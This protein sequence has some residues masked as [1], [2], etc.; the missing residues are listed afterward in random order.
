MSYP[1][2][3]EAVAVRLYRVVGEQL[4]ACE[5]VQFRDGAAAVDT[6]LRRARD[7]GRVDFEGEVQNHFADLLDADGDILATV[8]LDAGSYGALKN[9]WMRTR[10]EP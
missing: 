8:A 7:S 2:P 6:V 10:V 4:I 5:A 9:R 1:V 3:A